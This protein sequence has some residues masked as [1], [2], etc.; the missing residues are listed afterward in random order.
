MSD[1]SAVRTWISTFLK[2]RDMDCPSGQPLYKYGVN[3]TEFFCLVSAIK[4]SGNQL[5]SPTF[6]KY[7]AA[8][9][10]IFVAEQ[11][12]RDYQK[13]WAWQGFD[14]I[15]NTD[16]SPTD[17]ATVVKK[18]LTFWKRN[19]QRHS[20]SADYLGTLFSEGGLPWALIQSDKHGFARAISGGI[21]RYYTTRSSSLSLND[22]IREY[23]QYFPLTFRTEEKYQ[24]LS[25]IVESLMYLAE[26]IDLSSEKKPSEA[27]NRHYPGWQSKFPLPITES[28]GIALVDKWLGD[29]A[30]K[31][32]ERKQAIQQSQYFT[33]SHNLIRIEPIEQYESQVVLAPS[34]IIL[35]KQPTT[36]V[37]VDMLFIEGDKTLLRLGSTYGKLNKSQFELYVK[38]LLNHFIYHL[39]Y[40]VNSLIK[41]L[42]KIAT[43]PSMTCL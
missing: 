35:L 25:S 40:L 17:R 16:L 31:R 33:C 7:W 39:K 26:L 15:I 41:S 22:I 8:A 23:E 19:I 21:K 6:G 9:F 42:S 12:R 4:S 18:G 10:C 24:L 32:L 20:F 37:R 34:H 5:H 28:N 1:K 36:G 29:A 14:K 30:N 38:I 11:Y 43:L 27:L 3:E 13:T 2:A